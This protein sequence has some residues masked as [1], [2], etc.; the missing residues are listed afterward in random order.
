[1][2]A[3]AIFATPDN[4]FKFARLFLYSRTTLICCND[5]LFTRHDV[6]YLPFYDFNAYLTK[7]VRPRWP[8]WSLTVR[9]KLFA[10]GSV[11]IRIL[12]LSVSIA[13]PRLWGESADCWHTPAM[14][15]N[16]AVIKKSHNADIK[17]H[18]RRYADHSQM[19]KYAIV[20]CLGAYPTT[21]TNV[22]Q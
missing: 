17:S 22:G 6:L 12:H 21:F 16:N 4:N 18:S 2:Q 15:I 8:A 14:G 3:T 5:L 7:N 9:Y 13:E 11:T 10:G 19:H 20:I 1:M